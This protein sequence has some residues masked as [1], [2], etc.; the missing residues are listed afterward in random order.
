MW[1][2]PASPPVEPLNGARRRVPLLS[3]FLILLTSCIN[4]LQ[5]SWFHLSG[6]VKSA[7]PTAIGLWRRSSVPRRIPTLLHGPGCNL[8]N[9]M[10]CPIVVHYCADL[11]LVNWFGCY[12][13][14]CKMSAGQMYSLY[15]W[16]KSINLRIR[17]GMYIRL[18]WHFALGAYVAIA[19]KPVHQLQIRPIV[20]SYGN[21]KPFPQV[22]SG[23]V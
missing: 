14:K 9:G 10:G 13:I 6:Q 15:G 16:L 17:D 4:L 8:G 5:L 2:T 21:P 1:L 22:T 18:R 19:T 7:L 3:D 12:G 23:S 20:H 11:Q